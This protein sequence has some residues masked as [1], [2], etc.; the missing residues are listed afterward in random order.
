MPRKGRSLEIL[1][2][3]LERSLND[4]DNVEIESP[5]SI[6]DKTTGKMR[7]HDVILKFKSSHHE[8]LVAIE[9]RD[10]K[11]KV[12]SPEV[13]AFRQKCTDTNID[14]GI[15]VSTKGFTRPG[16]KKAKHHN[17]SCLDLNAAESFNWLLA[18]GLVLSSINIIHKQLTII[19]ER[20][21]KKDIDEYKIYNDDGVEV[22]NEILGNNV[23]NKFN[24]DNKVQTVGKYQ[25]V[26]KFSGKGL[27]ISTNVYKKPIKVK[28]IIAIVDYEVVEE[29]IPFDLVDYKNTITN[30]TYSEMAIAKIDSVG[31]KGKVVI[32]HNID[33][34]GSVSFIPEE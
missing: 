4:K 14:K 2:S 6:I 9:C 27:Q 18:P 15:I 31:I 24:K 5:K 21:L 17:I 28:E 20:D 23:V 26:L 32:T 34:W 3:H 33:K 13:E 29:L 25:K 7:E 11:T 12:G 19:P 10:R 8:I 22:T 1:I 30:E 16:Q